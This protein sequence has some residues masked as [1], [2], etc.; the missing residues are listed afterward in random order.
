[1]AN[2]LTLNATQGTNRLNNGIYNAIEDSNGNPVSVTTAYDF[3]N[4]EISYVI[5]LRGRNR[6]GF[7]LFTDETVDYQAKF[8]T[9]EY[10]N[11]DDL[12]ES[13]FDI[14]Q[15]STITLS[16]SDHHTVDIDLT[17]TTGEMATAALLQFQQDVGSADILGILRS[18]NK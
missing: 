14:I 1:M 18:L 7:F 10:E 2:T 6:C 9:I 15:T 12:V 16:G 5:D 17:T 8:T 13:D 4:N 11:T 3:D